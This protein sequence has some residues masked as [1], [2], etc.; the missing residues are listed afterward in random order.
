MGEKKDNILEEIKGVNDL[1]KEVSRLRSERDLIK[2][3]YDNLVKSI[4]NLTRIDKYYKN[5]L[6]IK[7]D[8]EFNYLLKYMLPDEYKL[9]FDELKEPDKEVDNEQ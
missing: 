1:V 2:N 6:T 7:D 3:K 8:T 4:F 5:L 9:R